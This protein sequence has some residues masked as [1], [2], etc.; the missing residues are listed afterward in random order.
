MLIPARFK[1]WVTRNRCK[2]KPGLFSAAGKHTTFKVHFE[3]ICIYIYIYIYICIYIFIHAYT[4]TYISTL[5]AHSTYVIHESL[6]LVECSCQDGIN[7]AE[8]T[9]A[10]AN[11]T[12][13]KCILMRD[14]LYCEVHKFS[15]VSFLKT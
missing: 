8:C 15:G 13:C 1:C 2:H 3:Y 7:T 10:L 9:H 4:H 14:A 5:V 12:H 6:R 11:T